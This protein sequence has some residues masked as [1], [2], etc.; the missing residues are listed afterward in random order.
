MDPEPTRPRLIHEAQPSSRRAWR[1]HD[2]RQRREGEVKTPPFSET[3]RIEARFLLR[4]LQQG[5]A[6][7]LPHSRPMPVLG[8]RCHELRIPDRVHTWRIMYHVAA[9]AIV[10]LGVFS[11]KTETTPDSVLTNCRRRLGRYRAVIIPRGQR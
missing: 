3:A 1:L 6:L 4:R 2:L 11:K 10:I 8:P 7:S 9:D 5:E